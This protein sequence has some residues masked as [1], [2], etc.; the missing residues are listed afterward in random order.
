VLSLQDS[1]Q[2]LDHSTLSSQKICSLHI[3]YSCLFNEHTTRRCIFSTSNAT[4]KC[5]TFMRQMKHGHP[6]FTLRTIRNTFC[7][8]LR[9]HS[10]H[11]RRITLRSSLMS[12]LSDTSKSFFRHLA[13]IFSAVH[14]FCVRENSSK[15]LFWCAGFISY[16]QTVDHNRLKFNF[17][18]NNMLKLTQWQWQ[19]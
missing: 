2:Y 13:A 10:H 4:R 1:L 11:D 7:M 17:Q 3:I 12:D 16:L 8:F 5:T 9:T 19:L 18:S 6:S 15:C 14:A